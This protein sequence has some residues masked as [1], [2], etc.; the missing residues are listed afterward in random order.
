MGLETGTFISD[1]VSSNPPSTDLESQGDDH[2][3][4]IK[5]VLQASFPGANRA[6]PIPTF[7]SK[8]TDYTIL[9]TDQNVTFGVVTTAGAKNITL[10]TL[11]G[12]DLGWKC[13]I[14][15]QSADVNP[16]FI[17]GTALYSGQSTSVTKLR[18]CIPF[19]PFECEWMGS[20]W[21][22]GRCVQVP[23]G[24]ILDTFLATANI[25]FGF[26]WPAGQALSSTNYP[27]YFTLVGANAPDLRGRVAAG[28]DDMN[29]SAANRITVGVSGITG[30]TLG[31]AGGAQSATIAQ[32]NLPNVNFTVSTVSP[33]LSI[34][35]GFTG[36]P[37]ST[38]SA[39]SSLDHTH[40]FSAVLGA[41]GTTAAGPGTITATSGTST[42]GTSSGGALDHTHNFTPAGTI[43]ASGSVTVSG[44]TAASGGSGTALAIVPPT[45]IMNKV[46]VVE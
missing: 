5:S 19:I 39:N 37:A 38:G 15:K 1:L 13:K 12:S 21:V 35:A 33:G 26:E 8:S 3:R 7:V 18:R 24:S 31:S 10:P 43:S 46:L 6:F 4:L 45:I 16:V 20:F 30:T 36:T 28:R 41:G 44:Q 42:T 14:V 17:L 25:P 32:A 2:L 22:V 11:G 40:Q 9:S 34:S 29:G 27:Q 23:V